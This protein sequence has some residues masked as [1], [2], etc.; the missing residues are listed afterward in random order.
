[1]DSKTKT[2]TGPEKKITTERGC[3]KERFCKPLALDELLRG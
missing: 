1:M 2:K 3:T